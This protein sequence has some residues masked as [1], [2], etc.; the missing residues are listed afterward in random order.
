VHDVKTNTTNDKITQGGTVKIT[1]HNLKIVGTDPSV[2]AEF[3]SYKD[4][5][6]F[7]P[8]PPIDVITNNPSELMVIAPKMVTGGPVLFRVTTQYSGTTVLKTSRSVTSD[9]MLIVV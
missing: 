1:G 3:V 5:G 9:R 8:I 7:Y 6:I 2:R 4:P